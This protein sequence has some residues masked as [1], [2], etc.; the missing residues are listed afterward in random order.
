M[1]F[2]RLVI[3]VVIVSLKLQQETGDVW[4]NWHAVG[5]KIESGTE[6]PTVI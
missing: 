1:T 3:V 4:H 2:C 6:V 5:A